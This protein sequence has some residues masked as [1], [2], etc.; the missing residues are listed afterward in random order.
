MDSIPA[1]THTNEAREMLA[2][3]ILKPGDPALDLPVDSMTDRE[4]LVEIL[5]HER[6]TR[7]TVNNLVA[8]IAS[9][10]LGAMMN[11]KLGG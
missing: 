9:S 6:N 11:G 3:G 7:D 1:V 10:P 8:A 4:I 5:V 2:A